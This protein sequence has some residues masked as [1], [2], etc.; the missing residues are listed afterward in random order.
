MPRIRL[1]ILRSQARSRSSAFLRL[2]A[3]IAS[4][5]GSPR[6]PALAAGAAVR[7]TFEA[8][9]AGCAPTGPE[10][11]ITARNDAASVSLTRLSPEG[12]ERRARADPMGESPKRLIVSGLGPR[13]IAA[14]TGAE[15]PPGRHTGSAPAAG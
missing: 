4:A 6:P 1:R 11:A 14:G 13:E 3:A 12:R 5:S 15:P 2:A 7:P 9:C 8:G 10:R